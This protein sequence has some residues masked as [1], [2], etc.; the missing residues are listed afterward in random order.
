MIAKSLLTR[1][2]RP[3]M[4]RFI[5]FLLTGVAAAAVNIVSRILFTFA[6]SY[7]VAVVLAFMVGMT[8]AFTLAKVFVFKGTGRSLRV[9]YGRF[10]LVNLAALVQVFA[11][12]VLLAKVVFPAIG[13][14]WH[15]ETI[16]HVVGVLSPVLVSYQGHKRFSF[17]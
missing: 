14:A 4:R 3:E 6:V 8:T 15:A 1:L 10:A 5:A 11:I 7:E 13:F 16:A 2:R 12:S 9:E 17:A